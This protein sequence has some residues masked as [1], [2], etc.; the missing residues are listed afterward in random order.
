MEDESLSVSSESSSMS[1][2]DPL[3]PH[4]TPTPNGGRSPGSASHWSQG[5]SIDDP[6]SLHRKERLEV[7]GMYYFC[8]SF[9]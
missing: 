4:L 8:S 1:S 2:L 3:G 6:R 9:R 7:D 5:T